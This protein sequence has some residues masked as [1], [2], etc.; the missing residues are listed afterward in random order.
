MRS[1]A[2]NKFEYIILS[3]ESFVHA[4]E[5]PDDSGLLLAIKLFGPPKQEGEEVWTAENNSVG[6]LLITIGNQKFI[7]DSLSKGLRAILLNPNS[8]ALLSEPFDSPSCD[9]PGKP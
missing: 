6:H 3:V 9:V 5:L 8:E 1:C 2:A 7:Y 4:N